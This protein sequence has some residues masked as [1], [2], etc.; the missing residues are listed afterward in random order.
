MLAAGARAFDL[1]VDGENMVHSFTRCK[2]SRFGKALAIFDVVDDIAEFLEKNPTETVLIFFKS[3]G[4]V[5]GKECLDLLKE[6][7]IGK[8][9]SLWYLENKF[10]ALSQVRGKIILLNR[11][12]GSIGIDF[13]KMPHQGGTK[14]P[15][16]ADFSPNEADTIT[17]QDWYALPRKRKWLEAVKPL[18]ES[19]EKCENKLALNHLSSA[20]LP[21][22]PKFNAAYINRKFMKFSLSSNGHY[23]IIMADFLNLELS[24]KIIKTN[25]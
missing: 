17:V 24:K 15:A 22:I 16:T 12:D 21:F 5:S 18:L 20:G 6:K 11:I 3:D 2:K 13:S 23:G 10:P 7:V 1:R 25:F 19:E 14:S 9:K 4:K 8:N